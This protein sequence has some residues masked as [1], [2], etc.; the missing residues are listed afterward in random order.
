MDFT[1][2]EF[3]FDAILD[4]GPGGHFF[5]TQH[6]LERY[7]TA[8]YAPLLSDWSNFETWVERGSQNA[9]QR[10][11]LLWKQALKEYQKPAL[12]PEILEEMEAFVAKRKEIPGFPCTELYLRLPDAPLYCTYLLR[13]RPGVLWEPMW[14]FQGN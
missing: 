2:P 10:A 13:G 3:A 7:E 11:N 1:E 6:T 5:G 14:Q 8:F 9:A 12:E 4:V